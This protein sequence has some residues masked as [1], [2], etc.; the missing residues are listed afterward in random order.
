MASPNVLL[1]LADDMGYGDLGLVNRGLS[2]TPALDRLAGESLRLT[3]AYSASC[4]CAPARAGLMTGRYPHRTGCLSL[5]DLHGLNH[6]ASREATAGDLFR[7]AGYRTGLVGKWHLGETADCHPNRRGFDEFF[8]FQDGATDYWKWELD[9]NGS[10]VPADGRYLTDVLSQAAVDFLRRRPADPFFLYLAYYTPHRPLQA[11]QDVL[12]RHL[13]RSDL[14]PGQ[15]HVYAMIEVMDRGIGQVLETL[16]ELGLADNTIVLFSSDNG[17]DPV[18]DGELSPQRF[19]CGLSGSKYHVHEGGIRIPMLFRWP[20]GLPAG[21]NDHNLVQF[22]DVLPTLAA[23]C[24]VPVPRGR[25]LDGEDRLPALRGDLGRVDP[26]RFWQW[27]RYTPVRACNAAMRDGPWKLVRPALAG[28]RDLVAEDHERL[29]AGGSA[30]RA[31]TPPPVQ[32]LGEPGEP[33]LY[34]IHEDPEERRNLAGEQPGRLRAMEG[35]LDGWFDDVMEDARS[36][37]A[38]RQG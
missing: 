27:N 14:T 34:D 25:R 21:V 7:G 13:A 23:A 4:V 5:N 1:I 28:F 26:V 17:P 31:V 18:R 12:A 22:I 8:G 6:L 32:Q 11:P 35:A 29:H 38:E 10:P 33:E 2:R 37:L 20:A 24:G 15:A 3:Q 19:N 30:R 16:D 9:R 36:A